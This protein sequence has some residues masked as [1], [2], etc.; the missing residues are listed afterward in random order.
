MLVPV[1]RRGEWVQFDDLGG[2]EPV[3]K[4]TAA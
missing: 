2:F 3:K 4:G 1:L